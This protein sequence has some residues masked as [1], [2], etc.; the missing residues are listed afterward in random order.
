M[1]DS[2]QVD[3]HEQKR[4]A[5]REHVQRPEHDEGVDLCESR[6]VLLHRRTDQARPEDAGAHHHGQVGVRPRL[7]CQP[8]RHAVVRDTAD[9]DR[10]HE[11]TGA[12]TQREDGEAEHSRDAILGRIQVS[13]IHLHGVYNLGTYS[14]LVVFTYDFRDTFYVTSLSTPVVYTLVEQTDTL[15]IERQRDRETER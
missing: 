13:C 9:V 15:P 4:R 2:A 12:A 8:R 11:D 7:E 1:G 6:A 10:Q 5:A 3:I 14:M